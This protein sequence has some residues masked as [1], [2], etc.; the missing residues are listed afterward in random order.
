MSIL[1]EFM[2]DTVQLTVFQSVKVSLAIALLALALN[3]A[4]VTNSLYWHDQDQLRPIKKGF[5]GNNEKI[6][7]LMYLIAQPL[8]RLKK[9]N[10]N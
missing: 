10:W 3:W 8:W 2:L 9:E 6:W 4:S 7:I 1:K 5:F